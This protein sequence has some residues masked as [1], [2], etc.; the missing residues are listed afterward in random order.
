MALAG[1]LA[2]GA[3]TAGA[4]VG[5]SLGSA[6][7]QKQNSQNL[8]AKDFQQQSKLQSNEFEFKK[9]LIERGENTFKSNGLP[10]FL[11]YNNSLA[12]KI[13][14]TETHL[15]GSAYA[16]SFGVG[17][18][19]P[20]YSANPY[21]Q[22]LGFGKPQQSKSTP[23]RPSV[24]LPQPPLNEFN[25]GPP[26]K[27]HNMLYNPKNQNRYGAVPWNYSNGGEF[28]FGPSGR[29]PNMNFPNSNRR[30]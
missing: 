20:F 17:S 15:G 28:N 5:A 2:V 3:I 24:D 23:S 7:I 19:L 25:G 21:S 9:G 27:F 12:D 13:P 18:N 10:S 4:T 26:G 30:R 1:A 6:G 14:N 16:S 8:Q 11:Y 22:I 29:I